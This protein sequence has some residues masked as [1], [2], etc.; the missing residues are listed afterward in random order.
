MVRHSSLEERPRVRR[1]SA[2]AARACTYLIHVKNCL[3]LVMI[4]MFVLCFKNTKKISKKLQASHAR[5]VIATEA[6]HLF[7]HLLLIACS[8]PNCLILFPK[9]A[10]TTLLHVVSDITTF[11][12]FQKRSHY[13][14]NDAVR[15]Q[16]IAIAASNLASSLATS[17]QDTN[18]FSTDLSKDNNK[19]SK[20]FQI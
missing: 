15:L 4:F 14:S 20:L 6:I 3:V 19:R 10:E 13:S 7:I 16:Y 9:K 18:L 12:L 5:Y 8:F 17:Q 2:A 11:K 1:H